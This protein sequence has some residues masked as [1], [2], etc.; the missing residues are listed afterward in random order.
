MYVN[1]SASP[2][3]ISTFTAVA[4]NT[5]TFTIPSKYVRTV[6]SINGSTVPI[7]FVVN[8]AGTLSSANAFVY[9]NET[10]NAE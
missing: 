9:Y 6:P 3:A 1:G 7:T 2:T 5:Y 10:S 8:A 4:G